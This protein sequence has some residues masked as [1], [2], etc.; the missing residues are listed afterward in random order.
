VRVTHSDIAGCRDNAHR[1][2][3]QG[4]RANEQDIMS[5]ASQ[6]VN[7]T[8]CNARL[9]KATWDTQHLRA[10]VCKRPTL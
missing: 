1:K 9:H 6:S 2:G 5:R 10:N 4:H 7:G 3:R 8:S